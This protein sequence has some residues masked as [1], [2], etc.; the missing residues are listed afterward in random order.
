MV[1]QHTTGASEYDL[2][3]QNSR[4]YMVQQAGYPGV[5]HAMLQQS[6]QLLVLK[7]W[8]AGCDMQRFNGDLAV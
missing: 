5:K 1:W 2:T 4:K 6:L 8:L 3:M 7:P